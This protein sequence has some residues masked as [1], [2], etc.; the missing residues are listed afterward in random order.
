[1]VARPDERLEALEAALLIAGQ[2]RSPV[3]L[4]LNRFV[5]ARFALLSFYAKSRVAVGMTP[6]PS[7]ERVL[8]DFV[9]HVEGEWFPPRRG[10]A[11]KRD[12][13]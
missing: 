2:C 5:Q 3:S 8:P 9:K 4:S 10:L 12:P 13:D 11:G 7:S 6:Q 1:M